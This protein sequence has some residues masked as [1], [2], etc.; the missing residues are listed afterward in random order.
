M[1][2]AE[3]DAHLAMP[4]GNGLRCGV[5]DVDRN[6]VLVACGA[7]H[8]RCHEGSLGD[9]VDLDADLAD[10]RE[11]DVLPAHRAERMILWQG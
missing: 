11:V 4:G 8:S 9:A 5:L 7:G 3:G 1:G 10:F 2:C 6:V